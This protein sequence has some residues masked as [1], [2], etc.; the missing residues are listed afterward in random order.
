MGSA[1]IVPGVSGGTVALVLG[2]YERLI[3]EIRLGASALRHIIGRDPKGALSTVRRIDWGWLGSLLLGILTAIAILSAVIERLLAEQ[4]VRT[5][6]VFSGLVVGSVLV[7]WRLIQHRTSAHIAVALGVGAGLFLLLG[8]RSDTHATGAE[9]VTQ[10]WWIFTAA[11]ALAICAMILPGI[12]G[13]FILVMIGMYT[14]VLGAV[15]DRNL[16]AVAATGIGC[17]IGLASFSTLLDW[18][19]NHH[20]DMVIA[21][22]VGL[23]IGSMR[24]LWPW[25]GGTETTR[26]SAPSG[27]VTV[28]LLLAA[29]AFIL[30]I[31]VDRVAQRRPAAT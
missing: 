20:H 22:M 26:L 30:V 21:A 1:D 24:V 13:S 19:L 11:G 5:A 29:A 7:A 2:I 12:S 10:P 9:I 31:T 6:A 4:P 3:A 23:M 16:V 25:P 18:M 8:L 17:V 27:D 14:E 15:N 28:P